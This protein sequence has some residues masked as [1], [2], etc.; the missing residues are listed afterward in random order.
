MCLKARISF[1]SFEEGERHFLQFIN[2]LTSNHPFGKH[3]LSD[4]HTGCSNLS[5]VLSLELQ[6]FLYR[7]AYENLSAPEIDIIKMLLF[8]PFN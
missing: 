2:D 4:V 6:C 3:P 5:M 8:F 7:V 1:F